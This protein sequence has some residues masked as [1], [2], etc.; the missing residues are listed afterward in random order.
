M[1]SDKRLDSATHRDFFR[2]TGPVDRFRNLYDFE[3]SAGTYWDGGV[4]EVSDQRG[5]VL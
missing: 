2:W 4:L 3:F 5:T 1:I